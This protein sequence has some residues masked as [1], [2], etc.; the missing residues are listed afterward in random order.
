LLKEEDQEEENR[1]LIWL[2]SL[3]LSKLMS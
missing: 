1:L 3:I 2:T